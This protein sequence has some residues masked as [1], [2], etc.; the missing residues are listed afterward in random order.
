MRSSL[1]IAVFFALHAV[2]PTSLALGNDIEG[3]ILRVSTNRDAV[4]DTLLEPM[5][6]SPITD[7][8]GEGLQRREP[9][10]IEGLLQ[11]RQSCPTGYGLCDNGKCCPL[12]GRCCTGKG[13]CQQPS[14]L[15]ILNHF[16]SAGCCDAGYWCYSTGQAHSARHSW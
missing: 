8:S 13:S 7:T 5:T 2:L 11:I 16:Y 14:P 6:G 1:S 4:P 9:S 12:G 15:Q 3:G 10:I